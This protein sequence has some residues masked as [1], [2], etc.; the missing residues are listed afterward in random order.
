ML[1]SPD[2]FLKIIS[3]SIVEITETAEENKNIYFPLLLKTNIVYTT[4]QSFQKN[5]N[6]D[7][8]FEGV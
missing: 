4:V 1:P 8:N 5:A 3:H 2:P 6:F 7:I